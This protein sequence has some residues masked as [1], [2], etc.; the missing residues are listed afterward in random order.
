MLLGRLGPKRW[1]LSK[2]LFAQ[3]FHIGLLD[4]DLSFIATE[5]QMHRARHARSRHAEGLT[6]HVRKAFHQVDSSVEFGHWLEGR[7]IVYLL[8]DATEL[9]VR[10]STTGQGDNGR[11]GQISV[12]KTGSQIE[13]THHLGHAYSRTPSGAS[14]AVS[15]VSG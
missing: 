13:S 3:Y 15:H 14:V 11:M 4:V 8:I 2:S 12:T 7:S 1:N 6:N 10:V 9:C 5:L